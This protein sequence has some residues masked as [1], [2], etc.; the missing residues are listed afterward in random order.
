PLRTTGPGVLIAFGVGVTLVYLTLSALSELTTAHPAR[1][2]FRAYAEQAFGPLAGFVVGWV[3]WGGLILA[4]SSEAVAVALFARLWL[5]GVP[6]WLISLTVVLLVSAIN[7]LDVA[8]FS[9]IE[10]VM[11]AVKVLAVLGF[12]LVMAVSLLGLLPGKPF[13]GLGAIRT[14][15]FLP[16]GLRGLFGSM[17]PV[18]FTFAGFEVLGMAA[19]DAEEP[20]RTV[21]RAVTLTVVSQLVLYMGAMLATLAVLAP[22]EVP[23]D[24][25]PMVATLLRVGLYPLA[26]ILNIV[27]MTAAITTM[28]AATYSLSRMLASLAEERQAPAALALL[29]PGGAPRNALL[30][31]SGFMLLGVLLSYL[32]PHQVYLFLVSAGGFSLIFAYLVIL[33]SHLVIR[34]RQGGCTPGMCQMTTYPYGN[35][36]G[37]LLTGGAIV[38]MPLVPGQGAG[39]AAGVVLVIAATAAYLLRSRSR[40]PLSP[41]RAAAEEATDDRLLLR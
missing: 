3:Y 6:V 30:V 18:F 11:A 33:A 20:A 37:I 27:V 12:I 19:P 26:T 4:M 24:T 32:L 28:L 38:T 16:T 34:R 23:R 8:K 25:S 15:S 35:W 17:L 41:Q 10:S 2:S 39:L 29:T 5:P 14:E 40:R 31:S 9:L 1:G 22:G 7:L 21:P 13:V 36:V